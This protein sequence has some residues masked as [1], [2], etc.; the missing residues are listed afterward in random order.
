[1][2]MMLEGFG[3]LVGGEQCVMKRFTVCA[4]GRR[5]A[6]RDEALHGGRSA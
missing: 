5:R 6:V 1:M 2:K 3:V 4:V